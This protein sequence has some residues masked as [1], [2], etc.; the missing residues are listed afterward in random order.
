MVDVLPGAR[1][2]AVVIRSDRAAVRGCSRSP[3]VRPLK[4]MEATR[5]RVLYCK[6]LSKTTVLRERPLNQWWARK[7]RVF[8]KD[9]RRYSSDSGH[10]W[11]AMIFLGACSFNIYINGHNT[12]QYHQSPES[13]RN[14]SSWPV[15]VGKHDKTKSRASFG[16]GGLTE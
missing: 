13:A 14:W 10:F 12:L 5:Y 4:E 7:P 16:A 2:P 1:S 15:L 8:G 11:A 9:R 3:S 6:I